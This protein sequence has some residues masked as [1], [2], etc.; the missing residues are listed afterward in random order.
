MQA[1]ISPEVKK[2]ENKKA[3]PPR[4]PTLEHHGDVLEDD[5]GSHISKPSDFNC[6]AYVLMT[7]LGLG[8]LMPWNIV[9][10]A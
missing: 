8:L 1:A 3:F 7:I 9:L 4:T 2:P 10:L 5:D 6:T